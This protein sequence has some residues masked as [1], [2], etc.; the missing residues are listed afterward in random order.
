LRL[1]RQRIELEEHYTRLRQLA[2]ERQL[3]RQQAIADAPE[4]DLP[5]Q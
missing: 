2:E 1:R 4:P 5:D 3:R